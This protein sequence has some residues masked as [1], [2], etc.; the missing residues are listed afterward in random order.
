M[1]M[2]SEVT[3]AAG[4][5]GTKNWPPKHLGTR[6]QRKVHSWQ[7][8]PSGPEEDSL[9]TFRGLLNGIIFEALFVAVVIILWKS[10]LL[11]ALF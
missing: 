10:A 7:C 9:G 1:D 11:R 8:M 2:E 6:E 5:I 4:T 3:V